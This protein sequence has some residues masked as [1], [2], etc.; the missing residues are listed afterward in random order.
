MSGKDKGSKT[1]LAGRLRSKGKGSG[2]SKSTKGAREREYDTD[3]PGSGPRVSQTSAR[4]YAS[5]APQGEP[6]AGPR[7]LAPLV[8]PE[9]PLTNHSRRTWSGS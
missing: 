2:D 6:G 8:L 3:G 4:A 1:N 9:P 5:D 7:D